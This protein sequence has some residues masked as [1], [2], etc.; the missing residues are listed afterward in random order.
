MNDPKSLFED[1]VYPCSPLPASDM[2]RFTQAE[3]H[4]GLVVERS[5]VRSHHDALV[6]GI[7]IGSILGMMIFS[8]IHA[9]T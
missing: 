8:K 9:I 2:R 3:I 6:A 5:M 1:L 7:R 4:G